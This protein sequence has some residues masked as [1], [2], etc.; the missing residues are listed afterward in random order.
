MFAMPGKD[1]EYLADPVTME[2]AS[3]EFISRIESNNIFIYPETDDYSD[4]PV[5]PLFIEPDYYEVSY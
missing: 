5:A 3:D 4:R 2:Y 1:L